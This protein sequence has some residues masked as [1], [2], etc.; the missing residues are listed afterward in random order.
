MIGS[1]LGV[2]FGSYELYKRELTPLMNP[3]M[4]QF[5]AG[6]LGA[7]SLWLVGMLYTHR[8]GVE[9]LWFDDH[10]M[11]LRNNSISNRCVKESYDGTS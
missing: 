7:T 3:A 8:Y 9:V 11:L 4:A 10:R 2:Y 5:I 1:F 6:G